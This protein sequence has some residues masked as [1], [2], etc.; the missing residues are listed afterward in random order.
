MPEINLYIYDQLICNKDV[1]GERIPF[2]EWCGNN[3]ICICKKN[4][5]IPH[6]IYHRKHELKIKLYVRFKTIKLLEEIIA[7]SLYDL[8]L[9]KALTANDKQHN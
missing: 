6:E 8:G 2:N 1:N 3:W 7:V 4:V 5:V 9:G